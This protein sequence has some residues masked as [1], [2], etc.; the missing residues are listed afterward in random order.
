MQA[1][2]GTQDIGWEAWAMVFAAGLIIFTLVNI[3]KQI[4]WRLALRDRQSKASAHKPSEAV[5]SR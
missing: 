2:F 5:Q 3:E 4:R 1:V